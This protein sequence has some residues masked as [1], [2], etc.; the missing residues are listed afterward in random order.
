MYSYTLNINT[1]QMEDLKNPAAD[2]TADKVPAVKRSKKKEYPD[3]AFID[4]FRSKYPGWCFI[5]DELT[6]AIGQKPTWRIITRSN[7]IKF[8]DHLNTKFAPNTVNQYATRL[9]VVL[10]MYAEEA[11]LPYS[12]KKILSPRKIPSTAIFLNEEELRQLEAYQPANDY[13]RLARNLFVCSAYSGAR[14]VD[15]MRMNKANIRGNELVFVAQKTHKESRLPLKPIVAQYIETMPQI[16]ITEKGYIKI[17]QRIC[18]NI[19]ICEPVKILKAGKEVELPKYQAVTSH[20]ARRSFATNLYIKGVD[21]YTISKL[22]QHSDVRL[23]AKYICTTI[24]Q[25]DDTAMEYFR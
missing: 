12:Y 1:W 25:L 10:S 21:I 13:E 20:T 14:Y 4:A 23:T 5:L 9:K 16:S 11:K 3:I 6:Q 19:G 24:K 7:L 2:K 22:M 18:R 8:I 15:I 17:I